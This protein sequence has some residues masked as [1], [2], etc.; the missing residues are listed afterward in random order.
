MSAV[1]ARLAAREP[2]VSA[3]RARLF[4]AVSAALLVVLL[5]CS[6]RASEDGWWYLDGFGEIG[7]TK[8]HGPVPGEYGGY[9]SVFDV[10]PGATWSVRMLPW[11]HVG[12]GFRLAILPSEVD[13]GHY[14]ALTVPVVLRFAIP[15]TRRGH[16]LQL[17]GGIGVGEYWQLLHP[18]SSYI[19]ES[20]VDATTTTAYEAFVGYLGPRTSTGLSLLLQGGTR[21]E[22]AD[23]PIHRLHHMVFFRGG[24]CWR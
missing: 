12:I 8:V 21:Y 18:V 4:G 22:D 9:L 10:G 2:I 19:R 15:L 7:L 14:Y 23:D 1:V 5:P 11:V 3:C 16:E 17:G 24:I 20:S 13:W 6:A